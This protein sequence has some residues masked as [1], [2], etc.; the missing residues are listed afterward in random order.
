MALVDSNSYNWTRDTDR[1]LLRG[2]LMTT[3]DLAAITK[4]WE[5]E[6]RVKTSVDTA[7]WP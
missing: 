4:P 7:K 1:N 6:Q 2:M 5:M 3:C